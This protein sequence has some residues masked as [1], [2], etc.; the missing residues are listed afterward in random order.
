M[1][2]IHKNKGFSLIEFVL[3]FLI[4]GIVFTIST[5]VVNNVLSGYK[6]QATIKEMLQLKKA[7]IGDENI[8][9]GK[10]RV[11][12]GYIGSQANFPNFS[13]ISGY[14]ATTDYQKDA[15]NTNY[16][17]NNGAATVVVTSY[18][19]NG[20]SGGSGYDEDIVI[21][22][23]KDLYKKN[24]VYLMIYDI[25]GNILRG[26]TTWGDSK[27]QIQSIDLTRISDGLNNTFT[28]LASNN[29]YLY[30]LSDVIVGV[31]NVCVNIAD[32]T[33][34]STKDWRPYLDVDDDPTDGSFTQKCVIYPQGSNRTQLLVVRLPGAVNGVFLDE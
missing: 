4:M 10:Q 29:T 30:E 6:Y 17:Y 23:N 32:G 18:G 9:K 7:L 22:I 24:H 11:D 21:S 2:D 28:P 19:K 26:R 14:F 25:R 20:A 34:A 31:Y 16:N 8:I 27:Y 1:Q 3:I 5:R 12:F 33:G 13:D 15:W